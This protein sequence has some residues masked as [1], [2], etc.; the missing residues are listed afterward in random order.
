MLGAEKSSQK[1]NRA[2]VPVH[3]DPA[4]ETCAHL[5]QRVFL[6]LKG[7]EFQGIWRRGPGSNRRIKVLQTSPLPLGYRALA[8]LLG[9]PMRSLQ[10]IVANPEIRR[11]T[12]SGRRDLNS[13]P[14]PW[15]GDALPLSYSRS[16]RL[17]IAKHGPQVKT[18]TVETVENPLNAAQEAA[19]EPFS[20]FTIWPSRM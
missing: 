13:R 20:S 14:S 2:F 8:G 5:L 18:V 7:I 19:K 9:K 10:V 11:M 4:K 1:E 12:W 3:F 16:T 17:S 15:Q 6:I